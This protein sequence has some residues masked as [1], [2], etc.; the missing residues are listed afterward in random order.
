MKTSEAG[1]NS[2][3]NQRGPQQ[4]TPLQLQL[5]HVTRYDTTIGSERLKDTRSHMWEE[6]AR[7][8]VTSQTCSRKRTREVAVTVLLPADKLPEVIPSH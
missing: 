1:I 4:N 6:S 5:R 2:G 3:D 7:A 8:A